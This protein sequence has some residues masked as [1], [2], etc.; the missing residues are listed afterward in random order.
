[1]IKELIYN[2]LLGDTLNITLPTSKSIANR[3]LVLQ[4]L[5][6]NLK[7]SFDS[8][9]DDIKVLQKCLTEINQGKTILNAGDAGTAFR[10]LTAILVLSK[11]PITLEGS[12]RMH[13]RPIAPLVEALR[14]LGCTIEYLQVEGYPPLKIYPCEY[15]KEEVDIDANISSQFISALMMLGTKLPNGLKLNL[16]GKVVSESY[17]DLTSSIIKEICGSV[18]RTNKSIEIAPL[19][20]SN[21]VSFQVESD[22]SSAAFWFPYF[23]FVPEEK[24]LLN[25]LKIETS[26]GDAQIMQFFPFE[27]Q[28]TD[29]GI[30]VTKT[31]EKIFSGYKLDLGSTPDLFPVMATFAATL[32]EPSTFSG[33]HHLR[34]KESDRIEAM[35]QELQK[36]G[37]FLS[38]SGDEIAINPTKKLPENTVSIST[39]GDH[40]MAMA[41]A[42]ILPFLRKVNIENP[43]VVA[44]SYPNY[45]SV[46][47]Q[48]QDGRR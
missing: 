14:S 39:W 46:L 36:I 17:I 43:E 30:M 23:Y 18:I 2:E 38:F 29:E 45:F 28:K 13:Q 16:V 19:N 40:R 4:Q 31:G 6:P 37:A 10:F 32:A 12:E 27:Y 21:P 44:K 8:D 24:M 35:K 3:A 1:M 11:V 15:F 22:W 34:F 9:S 42:A 7:L 5:H 26:Q 47:L 25:G 41:F 48:Q 20:I 33:L